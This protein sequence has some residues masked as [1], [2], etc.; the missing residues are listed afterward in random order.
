MDQHART[1]QLVR[2]KLQL[3]DKYER[4]AKVTTSKPKRKQFLHK[5]AKLRSQASHLREC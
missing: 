2:T 5:T 4:L 1:E 3:A